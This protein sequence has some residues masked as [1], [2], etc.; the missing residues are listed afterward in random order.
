MIRT[1]NLILK[2]VRLSVKKAGSSSDRTA[3]LSRSKRYNMK[4][5]PIVYMLIVATTTLILTSL[6]LTCNV[7]AENEWRVYRSTEFK[8]RFLYHNT[9][10]FDTPRGAN[11]RVT[12]FPP[13]GTYSANCNILVKTA[14]ELSAMK[15]EELN[16]RIQAESLSASDWATMLG[17][18]PDLKVIES[19]KVMVDN[20]PAYFGL[21]EL[22]HETFDRE[23]FI[24]GLH[25][26]TFTPGEYW[27]FSCAGKGATI[28]EARRSYEHWF[29]VF[30]KM[31][32]SFV[33][34]RW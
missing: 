1:L 14:T 3:L 23:V 22:S 9:W 29:P 25:W 8:F 10:R 4:S 13:K 30:K 15:Q 20:Q 28:E 32:G 2:R 12:L 31:M 16:R 33:F 26:I 24:R 18:W 7:F 21:I 11:V 6:I 27:Q 5:V 34:E 19:K 17:K